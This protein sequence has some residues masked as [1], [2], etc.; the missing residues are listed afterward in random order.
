M[1][2]HEQV[3][4]IEA[5]IEKLTAIRDTLADGGDEMEYPINA[6]VNQLKATT[7]ELEDIVHA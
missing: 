3:E 6:Q 1:K 5:Q 4:I 2:T 7:N